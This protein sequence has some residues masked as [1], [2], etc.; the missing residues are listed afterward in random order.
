MDVDTGTAADRGASPKWARVSVILGV[1][2][3]VSFCASAL[4][5][6]SWNL[7]RL[8]FVFGLFPVSVLKYALIRL[9]ALLAA[10][11]AVVTGVVS[12]RKRT[13]M[14]MAVIGTMTGCL[15]I[16]LIGYLAFTYFSTVRDD[17]DL[18][19]CGKNLRHLDRDVL[20]K[21]MG[22]ADGFYPPLSSQ[23]GVLMFSP[24]AIPSDE[25]IGI[26]LTCPT[27]RKAKKPTTGPASP[28]DDQSYFYLG[29]AVLDE[30]DIEAFAQAY[31]KQTAVGG[32]FEGDLAVETAEGTRILHRLREGAP[33]NPDARRKTPVFIE[34]GFGHVRIETVD[35]RK[36]RVRG[37][38]VVYTNGANEFVPL[39]A[40]PM[41][42]RTQRILAELAQ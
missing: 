33:V 22:T 36:V 37:G 19:A 11:A 32:T 38:R 8:P 27:M 6:K 40:W 9:M 24:K 39:G 25:S 20:W 14:V 41:T 35:G 3:F 34:R 1:L 13:R 2:S 10:T 12:I 26:S 21:Y 42:E 30:N 17:V 29:Y 28:F 31:R 7:W 23:R 4:F 18:T 16:G 5:I 15:T